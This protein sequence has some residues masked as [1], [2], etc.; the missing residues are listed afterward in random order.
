MTNSS[1]LASSALCYLAASALGESEISIAGLAITAIGSLLPDIDTPTSSVGRPLFPL[2]SWINRKVGHR[3]V[4][5]SFLGLG[6]F[7]ALTLG[8]AFLLAHWP[9]VSPS[10]V[11]CQSSVFNCQ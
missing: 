4:T 9:A 8:A 2:A 7:S 3:T 11:S 5:H 6:I 10:V 1:H